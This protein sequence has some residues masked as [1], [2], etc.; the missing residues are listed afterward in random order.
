MEAKEFYTKTQE[1]IQELRKINP[2]LYD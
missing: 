1:I 2:E